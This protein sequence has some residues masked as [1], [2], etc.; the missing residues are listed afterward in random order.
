MR[1]RGT[2]E[3]QVP[4]AAHIRPLHPHP[5]E[6]RTCNR[7]PAVCFLAACSRSS[8]SRRVRSKNAARSSRLAPPMSTFRSEKLPKNMARAVSPVGQC[9]SANHGRSATVSKNPNPDGVC[10]RHD[11]FR[12]A[13]RLALREE[14][15]SERCVDSDGTHFRT[16]FGTF[17]DTRKFLNS[18][19]VYLG[20]S[21]QDRR[22]YGGATTTW[23][24]Q[25]LE[26]RAQVRTLPLLTVRTRGHH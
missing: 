7:A 4:G 3:N 18:D 24:I 11:R 12:S 22:S 14:M 8:R 1:V 19:E 25:G 13:L 20:T 23:S 26:A 17:H 5:S 21:V 9:R 10:E 15:A 16:T 6:S 2:R